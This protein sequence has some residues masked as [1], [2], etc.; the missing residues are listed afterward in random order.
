MYVLL[1]SPM[2]VVSTASDDLLIDTLV[3]C[4]ER[5][6]ELITRLA[7]VNTTSAI[8]YFSFLVVGFVSFK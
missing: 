7:F 6:T 4:A 5:S 8:F 2:L 1:V 3:I